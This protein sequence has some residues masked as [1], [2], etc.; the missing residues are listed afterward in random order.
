M[1]DGAMAAYAAYRPGI[2]RAVLAVVAIAPTGARRSPR[3]FGPLL[4]CHA[5]R[6]SGAAFLAT[7][8]AQRNSGRILPLPSG[9]LGGR[10]VRVV[11]L[12][13][14]LNDRMR[15]LVRIELA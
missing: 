8:P 7:F 13:D 4:W 15:G 9:G 14:V 11:L 10:C 5:S 2:G 12:D 3:C 1:P 6:T